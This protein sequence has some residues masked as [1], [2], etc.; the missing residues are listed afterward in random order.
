[1]LQKED[2]EI[3]NQ[4]SDNKLWDCYLFFE[5]CVKKWDII[6]E[7]RVENID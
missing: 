4:K 5:N 2:F 3:K 6:S 7:K 1:M